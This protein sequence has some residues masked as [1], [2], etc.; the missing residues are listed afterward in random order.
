MTDTDLLDYL[1]SL[2]VPPNQGWQLRTSSTGRGWRLMTTSATPNYPTP[3][4]A[5]EA[6]AG[7]QGKEGSS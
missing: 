6:F 2:P 4:E 7:E 1:A 3:R 5:I